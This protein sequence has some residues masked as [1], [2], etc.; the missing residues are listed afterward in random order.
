M[1]AKQSTPKSVHAL[2]GVRQ[3]VPVATIFERIRQIRQAEGLSQDA[4]SKE[5][6]M[7]F[8]TLRNYEQGRRESM[9]SNELEKITKHPRFQKYAL[10]LVTETTAP[11]AGQISP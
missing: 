5:I 9:A 1:Y 7:N 10:W 3:V 8:G 2:I 11:G 6:G 4:F